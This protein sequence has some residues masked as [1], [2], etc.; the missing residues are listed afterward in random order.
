[1]LDPKCNRLSN[2]REKHLATASWVILILLVAF[3][4]RQHIV[5][6][7]PGGTVPRAV[8]LKGVIVSALAIAIW[9]Y[10]WQKTEGSIRQLRIELDQKTEELMYMHEQRHDLLNELTLA[11]MYL[12]SGHL[13]KGQ[14]C[15]RYAA[16]HVSNSI[17]EH[18]LPDDAWAQM[19]N[20]KQKEAMERGIDFHVHLTYAAMEDSGESHILARLLGNLLDNALEAATESQKPFVL[21]ACRNSPGFRKLVIG[22]NGA[23]IPLELVEKVRQPGFSTKDGMRGYGLAICERLAQEM[24]GHLDINSDPHAEWTEISIVIPIENKVASEPQEKPVAEAAVAING[25]PV[26]PRLSLSGGR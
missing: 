5:Y 16:S 7:S 24:G 4:L 18:S 2:N 15:L 22:N 9:Y 13:E 19:I 1:M 6:V 17:S 14:Q 11:L 12:Q 3:T 8:R 20:L 21:I 25:N 10:L 26:E 23:T